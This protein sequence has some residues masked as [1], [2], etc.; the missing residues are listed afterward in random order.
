LSYFLGH[1]DTQQIVII[2]STVSECFEFGWK[3]FDYAEEFQTPV[4][5]LSDLD[6]GMNLWMTKRFIYPD[7]PINRGKILWEKEL[8]N[9]KGDWGRYLDVDGDGIPYRTVMGNKHKKAPYFA[10]GTGHDE[11]GNYSEEPHVWKR[12]NDRIKLKFDNLREKLPQPVYRNLDEAR[13]GLIAVGSAE[14][15]MIEAQDQ[16]EEK[17]IKCDFMRIRALP[18]SK[19]VKEFIEKHSHSY[20][21]ELNRDGQLHQIL[22][23]EYC[24]LTGRLT[25]LAY[26]DGLPITAEWIIDAVLEKEVESND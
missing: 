25:S 20:V 21:I 3:A 22:C 5:I 9:F 17:G 14:H 6:L 12:I 19:K 13:I 26:L 15:A 4:I 2:P 23:M 1:G 8:E 10:R 7:K 18:F 11:F 16:L 24:D